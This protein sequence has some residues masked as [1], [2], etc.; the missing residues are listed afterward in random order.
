MRIERLRSLFWYL[1][2]VEE[3]TELRNI[4]YQHAAWMYVE[5]S[6]TVAFPMSHVFP[7][8]VQPDLHG[9]V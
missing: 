6:S 8:Q 3:A 5:S 4:Y 7:D 1:P 9:S 2:P